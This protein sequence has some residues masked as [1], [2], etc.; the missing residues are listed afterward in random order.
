[1][2][3]LRWARL[4]W[5]AGFPSIG[6]ALALHAG[7]VEEHGEVDVAGQDALGLANRFRA[8]ADLEP[9]NSAI[10]SLAVGDGAEAAMAAAR[11]AGSARVGRL[12]LSFHISTSE[13][14]VDRAIDIL[15]PHILPRYLAPR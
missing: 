3:S 6:G 7:V 8:G 11:I 14:D 2:T 10:V 4:I 9:G 15:R 12:R 1:V 5:R 13:A